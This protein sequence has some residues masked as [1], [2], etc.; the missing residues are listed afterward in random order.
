M[1]Y[2]STIP[3]AV[4][5]ANVIEGKSMVRAWREYKK[6]TQKQMAETLGITQ[7]AYSQIEKPESKLR[8]ATLEKIAP[9]M[10]IMV[11]QLIE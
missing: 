8:H 11:E 3:H 5:G 7:A 6:L 10:G 4:V 1:A 2:Q 9:A